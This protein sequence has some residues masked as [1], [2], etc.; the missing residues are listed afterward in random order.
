MMKERRRS[1]PITIFEEHHELVI[2]VEWGVRDGVVADCGNC[3]LH[4][5]AHPDMSTPQ[6]SCSPGIPNEPDAIRR[7]VH[8]E[9]TIADFLYF[10]VFRGRLNEIYW[11]DPRR[12]RFLPGRRMFVGLTRNSDHRFIVGLHDKR[13]ELEKQGIEVQNSTY[14]TVWVQRAHAEHDLPLKDHWLVDICLDYFSCNDPVDRRHW[15]LEVSES[16]L[17]EFENDPYHFLKL[18]PDM[19]VRSLRKEGKCFLKFCGALA[20]SAEPAHASREE[21]R[22]RVA[23]IANLLSRC[24]IDPQMITLSRSVVSGFTPR[25]QCEFIESEVYSVLESVY[26]ARLELISFDK[27]ASR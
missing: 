4:I 6:P 15:Q 19:K 18:L 1:I 7:F 25:D 21:I 24:E 13:S 27:M 23:K 22:T 10:L 14:K 12:E 5:D 20:E 9:L 8:T 2:A 17:E 11:V 16:T 26:G 3:L